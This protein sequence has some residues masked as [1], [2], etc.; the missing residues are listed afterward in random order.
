MQTRNRRAAPAEETPVEPAPVQKKKKAAAA[1]QST[2]ALV[3]NIISSIKEENSVQK[4]T[5]VETAKKTPPVKVAG[6]KQ[7]RGKPKSG[8][9]WK[10]VKQR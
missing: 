8:R 3:A 10:E 7:I 1:K 9:P 2:D 5:E 6:P 4:P